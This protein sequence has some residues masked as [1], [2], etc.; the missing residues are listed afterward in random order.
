VLVLSTQL[1][2]LFVIGGV[3]VIVGVIITQRG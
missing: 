1:S 3:C 2:L